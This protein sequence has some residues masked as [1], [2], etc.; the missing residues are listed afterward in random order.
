MGKVETYGGE[1]ATV[2]RPTGNDTVNFSMAYLEAYVAESHIAVVNTTPI[3]Q[4]DVNGETMP[5]SPKWMVNAS[6]ERRFDFEPGSL[7]LRADG[8]YT[9]EQYLEGFN[10]LAT[11]MTPVSYNNGTTVMYRIGDLFV[12][13]D[14]TTYDFTATYM[15][16]NSRYSVTAY[17]KNIT[18]DYYKIFAAMPFTRV[19]A[20]RTYGA[21]FTV[22]F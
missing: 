19:T 9:S 11:G 22:R 1:L 6:Y 10:H 18:D 14:H 8:R 7:L 17:V 2:W 15:V 4:V 20:P 3:E 12:V 16:S 21:T 13:K 5:E